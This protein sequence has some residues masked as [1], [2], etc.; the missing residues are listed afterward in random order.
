MN[1]TPETPGAVTTHPPELVQTLVS[2]FN[3]V[4]NNIY[5]IL[6]PV[7]LDLFLWFGPHLRVKTLIEP[8]FIE[9]LSLMRISST[10]SMRPFWDSLESSFGPA[11]ERLN[12]FS[13][14]STFPLGV[15]SLTAGQRPIQ[16]PVGQPLLYEVQS[17]GQYFLIWVALSL[18]GLFLGCVYFAMIAQMCGKLL[19]QQEARLGIEVEC[20]G[21]RAV[22]AVDPKT[23]NR[24][25]PLR[26]QVLAWEF[27]QTFIFILLL[28]GI[29]LVLTLPAMAITLVLASISPFLSSAAI[30]LVL[31]SAI[32]FIIPLV[33]SP[34][35]IFLCGQSVFNAMLNS[36]RLVRFIMPGTGMFLLA[37]VAINM[38]QS[39]LWSTP[40]S[41]SWMTLVGIF[42]NAFIITAL[43][44]ASFIYYRRGLAYVQSIRKIVAKNF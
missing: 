2:G 21:A 18:L 37:L 38:G 33:F 25:P 16:T 28:L 22:Q 4:A 8:D 1:A 41:T 6:L 12:L 36:M 40:P 42:G 9:M 26:P 17:Y 11:L 19:V 35:G 30:L 5:L 3:V 44:A 43:L 7:V 39:L 15:P 32:W 23:T 31:F 29:M 14:L 13:L 24:I 27:L 34:H 20:R 10:A